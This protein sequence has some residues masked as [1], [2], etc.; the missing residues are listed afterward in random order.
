MTIEGYPLSWPRRR[1]T[2]KRL[3]TL[4]LCGRLR[5]FP[6]RWHKVDGLR[7]SIGE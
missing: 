5:A 3:D 2:Q 7:S 4:A 1:F 6:R